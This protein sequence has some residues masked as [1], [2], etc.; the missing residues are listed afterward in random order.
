MEISNAPLQG[1]GSLQGA[2]RG[3]QLQDWGLQGGQVCLVSSPRI[4][5]Q[6]AK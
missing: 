4:M 1:A 2:N 3:A 5:K 6:T